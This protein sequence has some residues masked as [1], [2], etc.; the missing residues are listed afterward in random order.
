MTEQI[1]YIYLRSH[2]SY[3]KYN[4]YKFGKA[5]NMI[6]RDSVYATGEIKR[7]AFIMVI[8]LH[9]GMEDIIEKSLQDIFTQNGYHIYI[10]GGVEFYDKKIKDLIIPYLN[11]KNIWFERLTDKELIEL[12]RQIRM[13]NEES[14]KN[15]DKIA[16][17][18]FDKFTANEQQIEVLNKC[19]E[20]YDTNDIGKLIWSCGLGKTLLG[21]MII[22]KLNFKKIV[23]GVP[24]IFLQNQFVAEILKVYPNDKNI[25]CVGGNGEYSTTNVSSINTFMKT[26]SNEPLF[27]ITTYSS[28]HLLLNINFDF[29]IGDEAHHLVGIEDETQNY[30]QF[31]NIHRNKTLFM[32]ATEKNIGAKCGQAV[33]SMDDEELFGNYIDVKSVRWAIENKKITDYDLLILSNTEK[34]IDIVI[35]QLGI[36]NVNKDLFMA[37]F[38]ALKSMEQ[39]TDLT[40]ILLCCNKTESADKVIEYANIVLNKNILHIDKESMYCESLHSNKKININSNDK[41]SEISKFK[42]AKYGIISSVYIFGEGFDLPKL[43]GVVFAENMISDIRIVQTALRPNRLNKD[44]PNKVARIIIPY[45]D[46]NDI[47]SDNE[48]FNR[49]RMIIAKLRNVDEQIEQ[50]I[51]VSKVTIQTKTNG[52]YDWES[53][54]IDDDANILK[55]IKLRLIHSSALGSRESVEQAEYNYVKQLNHEMNILSKEEYSSEHIKET[56]KNYIPRADEY[57]RSKGVWDNWCDFLGLEIEKYLKTKDEWIEFCKEHNVDSYKS[58]EELCQKYDCLPKNPSDFYKGFTHIRNELGILN[59]RR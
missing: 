45:L 12:E 9:K 41:N 49:V 24:S 5:S 59:K 39:Y 32:T 57:F 56:H 43:N 23:V 19:N 33:Y 17:D 55:K 11:E 36:V 13:K 6:D 14:I 25:L 50:K 42:K 40:H 21:I 35:R 54:S 48:S 52:T 4:A 51:T 46:C 22:K 28:C 30:K 20:F 1:A 29:M 26:K 3:E 7:G 18:I 44:F 15:K 8:R 47:A 53:L 27:V 31:H 58:Y 34:E 2:E 38:M 10:D 37:T 16:D